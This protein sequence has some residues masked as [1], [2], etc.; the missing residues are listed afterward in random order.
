MTTFCIAAYESY[1]S[2]LLTMVQTLKISTLRQV[3][4]RVCRLEIQ[5]GRHTYTVQCVGGGG[6]GGEGHGV[7]GLRQRNTFTVYRSIFF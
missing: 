7:L 3:L 4:I 2:T 1:L 5:S 6:R